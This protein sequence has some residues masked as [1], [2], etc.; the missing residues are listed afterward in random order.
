[1]NN[2]NEIINNKVSNIGSLC[3]YLRKREELL[4]ELNNNFPLEL[5]QKLTLSQKIWCYRKNDQCVYCRCGKLKKWLDNKRGWRIT[6]GDNNCVTITR[7]ETNVKVYGC[8]NPIKNKDIR[9]KIY[10]TNIEKYGYKSPAK[11]EKIKEKISNKWNDK[12]SEEKKEIQEKR[13]ST[14]ENKTHEEKEDVVKKRKETIKNL[15]ENEK[16][17]T[18]MFEQIW[19]R[20]CHWIGFSSK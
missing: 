8:D 1:M 18:N 11:N 2:L 5:Q 7:K 9:E 14:W 20:I 6:C 3:L 10:N 4:N 19:F 17:D 12:T 16:S 13:N 15:S